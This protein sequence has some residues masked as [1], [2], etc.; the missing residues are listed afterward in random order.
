MLMSLPCRGSITS[1]QRASPSTRLTGWTNS[2]AG[3]YPGSM[4][5]ISP[6]GLGRMKG[7][8]FILFA[9][10][11]LFQFFGSCTAIIMAFSYRCASFVL[12]RA[13]KE[14]LLHPRPPV[15]VAVAGRFLHQALHL[16]HGVFATDPPGNT[17]AEQADDGC[18]VFGLRTDAQH[19]H[20]GT[21]EGVQIADQ[22]VHQGGLGLSA[23]DHQKRLAFAGAHGLAVGVLDTEGLAV[24]PG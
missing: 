16:L 7:G 17:V 8:F 1:E 24:G 18:A 9:G 14:H 20:P 22:V 23:V 19:V 12:H 15:P 6:T 3:G 11:A 5:R 21:V 2:K 13:G 10:L 4:D